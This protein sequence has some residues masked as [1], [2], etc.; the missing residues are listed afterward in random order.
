MKPLFFGAFGFLFAGVAGS[1]AETPHQ[2]EVA[3]FAALTVS[4]DQSAR[5]VMS[6]V[7]AAGSDTT[8]PPCQALVKFFGPD[9]SLVG[10]VARI[11]LRPGESRSIAVSHPLRLLRASV[12]LESEV[13]T[14]K[15][16][17]LKARVEVFDL[18]TG[19]TF[20]S[21][22]A[23]PSGSRSECTTAA[24]PAPVNLGEDITAALRR[25]KIP[26]RYNPQ[27]H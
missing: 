4:A 20:V 5:V 11:Q 6:N 7:T 26:R 21:V 10:E 3:S 12:A 17:E 24:V 1:A 18:Q 16:C 14:P 23:E 25:R 27:Q 22:A 19:T 13:E 8:L 2:T 15:A 9:G